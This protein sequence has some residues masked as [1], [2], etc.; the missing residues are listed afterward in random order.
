MNVAVAIPENE[1]DMKVEH[2]LLSDIFSDPEFNIRGEINPASIVELAKDIE[3]QGLLQPIT[4]RPF[5]IPGY[6]YKV[7]VGH[8]RYAAYEYLERE[9]IPTILREG[10]TEIQALGLNFVEN[11]QRQDLN[12]LQEA[13]GIDRFIKLGATIGEIARLTGQ[14]KKWVVIRMG[15]LSMAEP[16]QEA[17]AAGFLTQGQIYDLS[18]IKDPSEQ[19]TMA[20][21]IKE[22]K[23][24]NETRLPV[25]KKK[26][27]K[28]T[29]RKRRNPEEI[30]QM[31]DHIIEEM[32][33]GNLA[34]RALAWANGEISDLD[35]YRDLVEYAKENHLR[36]SPP[37]EVLDLMAVHKM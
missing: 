10:L 8:R 13:H 33:Q 24:R 36:Y 7:V 27:S 30:F 23:L 1:K 15:L 9:T 29:Q 3:A 5:D 4:V 14:G 12:I 31:I 6:K 2:F 28:P 18:E 17:A 20:K 32:G 21:A 19:M 37:V 34:T 26:K 25:I 16:I 22:A 35:L 11:I